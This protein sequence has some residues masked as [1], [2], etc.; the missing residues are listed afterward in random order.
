[1]SKLD[2]ELSVYECLAGKVSNDLIQ[3][4][5]TNGD[6]QIIVN[7]GGKTAPLWTRVIEHAELLNC[8][9]THDD[10][11]DY[12][13]NKN[14]HPDQ[15]D[16]YNKYWANDW[17]FIGDSVSHKKPHIFHRVRI[18]GKS[19]LKILKLLS[20]ANH[21]GRSASARV[22]VNRRWSPWRDELKAFISAYR[23]VVEKVVKQFGKANAEAV[24]IKS[25]NVRK[26]TDILIEF[27]DPD[28]T[29]LRGDALIEHYNERQ[30]YT[31][32][33]KKWKTMRK[34]SQNVF[35]GIDTGS[36]LDHGQSFITAA[37]KRYKPKSAQK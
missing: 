23:P 10:M 6:M 33:T 35:R 21:S 17:G 28:G 16:K 1:M 9:T 22:D 11:V 34:Y 12:R 8:L 36:G 32:L 19:R 15:V 18:T 3:D 2:T 30:G 27:L 13:A 25:P 26:H 20:D 29:G 37:D 7:N 24:A 14:I 5:I 4:A 31:N